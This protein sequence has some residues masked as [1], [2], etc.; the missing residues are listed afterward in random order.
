MPEPG[1]KGSSK[2]ALRPSDAA[3]LTDSNKS[4][5]KARLDSLAACDKGLAPKTPAFEGNA[6]EADPAVETKFRA[7][8]GHCYRVVVAHDLGSLVVVLNDSVGSRIAESA[9]GATP[10]RARACFTESDT[11]TVSVAGGRGKG[12]FSLLVVQD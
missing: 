1:V 9:T 6:S 10:E 11:V 3:C 8:K 2:V 5:L 7:E 12:R 4:D